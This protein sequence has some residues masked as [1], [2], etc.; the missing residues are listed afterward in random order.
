[1]HQGLYPLAEFRER[2][3]Y[4][5]YFGLLNQEAEEYNQSG[6][7]AS[8]GGPVTQTMKPDPFPLLL[9]HPSVGRRKWNP[10]GLRCEGSRKLPSY[11]GLSNSARLEEEVGKGKENRELLGLGMEKAS[12]GK[13]ETKG[14]EVILSTCLSQLPTPTPSFSK[15]ALSTCSVT[16]PELDA[17]NTRH[18]WYSP[19][20][21]SQ[22]AK[23]KQQRQ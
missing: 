22:Q 16:V 15:Y 1:M 7:T 10:E 23:R 4:Q 13:S 21:V 8:P 5:K 11:T 2:I 9:Q 19:S 6:S 17:R 18:T 12:G 3:I 14:T 20:R